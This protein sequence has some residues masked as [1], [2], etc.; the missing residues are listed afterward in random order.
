M[1]VVLYGCKTSSLTLRDE[2]RQRVFKSKVIKRYFGL[3]KV[4]VPGDCRK[5]HNEEPLMIYTSIIIV[6]VI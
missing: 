6:Q 3:R 5:L 2:H 1:S 4:E